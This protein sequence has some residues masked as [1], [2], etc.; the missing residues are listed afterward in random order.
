[1]QYETEE[2]AKSRA[3]ENE[4]VRQHMFKAVEEEMKRAPM[5]EEG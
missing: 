3:I 5:A 4:E 1:V 2:Y